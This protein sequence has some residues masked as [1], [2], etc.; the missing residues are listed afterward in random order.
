MGN[1]F[2]DF[3]WQCDIQD[4]RLSKNCLRDV[5]TETLK[6]HSNALTSLSSNTPIF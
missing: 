1:G 4:P 3:M 5:A 6:K 2:C